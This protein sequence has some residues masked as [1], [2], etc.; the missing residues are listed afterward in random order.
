[1]TDQQ[2]Y[3]AHGLAGVVAAATKMSMVDGQRGHL[4]IRGY[5][6]GELAGHH[7]FEEALG[8][9]WD[10]A[11]PD[12][13]E[14]QT[15][16]TALAEGRVAAFERLGELGSA[17][18]QNDAMA[19]LRGA[20]A[21]WEV[22]E[23]RRGA[24]KLIGALPVWVGAWWRKRQGLTPSAPNPSATHSSDTLAMIRGNTPNDAERSALDTYLTTVIDHGMNASTFTARVVAS[25]GSDLT[26]AVA[27]AIGALKGPL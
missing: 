13:T 20:T 12:P 22:A 18:E 11:L 17:L 1:M 19:A 8:L 21:Q 3:V 14:T 27:A 25:T 16:Q 15:I 2:Q 24:L 9:L 26:S 7:S 23:T 10:G 5:A 6:L 4:V